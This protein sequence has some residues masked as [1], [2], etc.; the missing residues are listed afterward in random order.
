M[1]SHAPQNYICPFCRLLRDE[2][3][4]HLLS[5]PA[6][7]VYRDGTVTAFIS[8]HQWPGNPGNTIIVPD[9]HFE[10]IF[11][12]P[13]RYAGPIQ[14]AAQ[15]IAL[16]M[17]SAYHCQGISTRQH[18]EPAGYQDVWHYH[19]HITPRF[20]DDRLYPTYAERGVMPPDERAIYAE[21]LR[22]ALAKQE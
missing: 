17:K 8:S 10:N 20:T 16:A 6:D 11:D 9:E 22:T 13:L 1:F 2:R 19:V 15:R 5:K 18:N 21:K 14:R 12:L 7:I 3:D 4:E